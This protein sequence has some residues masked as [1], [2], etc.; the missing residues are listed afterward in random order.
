VGGPEALSP[1]EVIR[2]F[3]AA[4]AAEITAEPVP[5]AD[6]E[7]QYLTARD[8]LQKSFAALMLGYADGDA[9]DIGPTLELFPL[10]L[11]S[12]RDYVSTVLAAREPAGTPAR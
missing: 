3:E 1:R 8:P 6:L 9:M 12:V 10:H 4:G 7:N 2:V 11:T 5:V